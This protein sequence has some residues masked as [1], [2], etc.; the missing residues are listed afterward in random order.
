MRRL[1][2]ALLALAACGPADPPPDVVLITIDT[3]RADR[4]GSYGY[5]DAHTPV[6]D[7]L[8]EEGFRFEQVQ[9]PAPITAPAHATIFTG[10][11]P[12]SHGVRNNGTYV[13]RDDV[14][15]L[16]E[17][18]RAR[19]YATGA[20][21]AAHPVMARYGLARGF[22]HYDDAIPAD[23][24][25]FHEADRPA[26]EVVAAALDWARSADGDR[27]LFLWVH[28]F[29][30]HQPYDLVP[31]FD[32]DFADRPYDGEIAA[33]DR[34]V[35]RLL[36]GLD[37][38]RG[39]SRLTMVTS[40]HG[41]GL[42]QHDEPTHALLLYQTT[43]RVPWIVHWPG[44][45]PVG[46]E[47]EPVG[48]IDLAPTLTHLLGWEETGLRP[49]GVAVP[50]GRTPPRRDLFA[51]SLFGYETYRW[52]PLLALRHGDRKAILGN[53]RF[54]FDLA[55]DPDEESPL[56]PPPEDLL[57][58]LEEYIRELPD[59]TAET[60]APSPQELEA[61]AALGYAGGVPTTASG[62]QIL[63]DMAELPDPTTRAEDFETMTR[64][65]ELLADRAWRR[66]AD[67]LAP[68]LA[69]TPDNLWALYLRG[70]AQLELG[71][72]AG[73]RESFGRAASLAGAFP[74]LHL[75]LARAA[76]ALDDSVSARGGFTRALE[77][78]P[79]YLEARMEWAAY[80]Q[81]RRQY[82][83]AIAALRAGL[84]PGLPPDDEA[85]LH[86]GLARVLLQAGDR[87][88]AR[89]ALQRAR[90]LADS[91]DLRLV[92]VLLLRLESRWD[93]IVALL[94]DDLSGQRSEAALYRGEA[95]HRLGQMPEAERWYRRAIALQ[96][97]LHLAR[98]NLAWLL[99]TSGRPT[100]ALP[101][102]ERAIQLHDDPEYHDTYLEV[103]ERLGRVD[104]AR[105]HVRP[106]LER[107]PDHAG[108][109][110]RAARYGG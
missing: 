108:L 24:P 9:S 100:E 95:H 63:R 96:S 20:A 15:T 21:V 3:L 47:P 61:L 79:R 62:A 102:A 49:E 53:L 19:G 51:E 82:T 91:D 17:E 22:D 4:L 6:L 39:R 71:D 58:R 46:T 48:L 67:L 12:A 94:D 36:A 13:L 86:A 69:A 52:S 66:A 101:H 104:D 105:A 16:A 18:F 57:D 106:L 73:A 25:R 26:D 23:G 1:L 28:L 89:L 99:A 80:L 42:G 37:D 34:A 107:F 38:A 40:D 35:G 2:P 30:P 10:Q 110:A 75:G 93:E 103:L 98:N 33:S 50:P 83:E 59:P 87:P 55:V 27:P 14:P 32:V 88:A 7:R 70:I 31:P 11:L 44:Q 74:Q 77:E 81:G 29:D 68:L 84:H 41:E 5:A 76:V 92:E 43:L 85:R 90:D 65:Q 54:G 64:A 56:D 8:A 60:R 109:A 72:H 97:D 78:D 45:V